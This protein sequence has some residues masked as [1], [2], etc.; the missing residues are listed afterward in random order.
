MVNYWAMKTFK[1]WANLFIKNNEIGL[2]E[3]GVD[4][5][6]TDYEISEIPSALPNPRK[7]RRF[8]QLCKW[9]KVGDYIIV[10]IGRKTEFKMKI[11]GRVIGEYEFNANHIPY[12][13][14]R[15]I[16]IMR[17]FDKPVPVEKWSQ[18]QRIELVDDN[19]FVDTLI[20]GLKYG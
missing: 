13:H 4:K 2:G 3:E 14:Y 11:I 18:M 6:Y 15:K 17:V 1:D 9:V 16:E 20:K 5:K 10:G 8:D 12:W 19:D 7:Q